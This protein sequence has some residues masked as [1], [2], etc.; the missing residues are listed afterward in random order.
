MR[1]AANDYKT[2]RARMNTMPEE[3]M[4]IG[5]E[6]ANAEGGDSYEVLN[7]STATRLSTVPRAGREDVSRAIDAARSAFDSGPWPRMTPGERSRVLLRIAELI[8]SKE[9][10]LARTETQNQGKP[11]KLSRD[12]DVP[13]CADNIRFFAGASRSLEGKAASEFNGLGTS[14]VRKE[15]LGVVA[16]ITPWNYPLMMAVWKVIP[17]IA[18]GNCVVAKPASIT[19]LTTLAL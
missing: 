6:W 14:F 10:E 5:G 7:P 17:A 4:F 18:V 1:N 8:E 2:S 3:L 9:D 19:P 11:I 13:Y 12:S 16:C 15:P